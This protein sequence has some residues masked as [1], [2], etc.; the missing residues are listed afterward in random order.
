M[1][2][3]LMILLLAAG[4]GACATQPEATAPTVSAGIIYP[5][6]PPS[7]SDDASVAES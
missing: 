5:P 3:S 4:L 2:R 7:D 6:A 1:S